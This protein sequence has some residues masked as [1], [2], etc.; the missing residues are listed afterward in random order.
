MNTNL[1][2]YFNPPNRSRNRITL[3][4]SR[5]LPYS[6]TG[7]CESCNYGTRVHIRGNSS[8]FAEGAVERCRNTRWAAGK[9]SGS[10]VYDAKVNEK[11][12][13]NNED[14][15]GDYA[16]ARCSHWVPFFLQCKL[17][18]ISPHP[19]PKEELL[20][21]PTNEFEIP[22]FDFIVIKDIHFETWNLGCFFIPF[23]GVSVLGHKR[24]DGCHPDLH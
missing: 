3:T 15:N 22:V 11:E 4:T 18:H 13:K 19:H 2:D 6:M 16:I 9:G 1:W 7:R 17:R 12:D 8:I 24:G 23:F 10:H 5:A 21:M 20:R 14:G